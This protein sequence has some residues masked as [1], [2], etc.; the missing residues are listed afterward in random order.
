MLPK[1]YLKDCMDLYTKKNSLIE[2]NLQLKFLEYF[3][4]MFCNKMLKF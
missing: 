2:K 3:F 1:Y 4:I